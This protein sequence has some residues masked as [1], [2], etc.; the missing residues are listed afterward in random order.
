M[1]VEVRRETGR[2][3]FPHVGAP[4]TSEA[5]EKM[6]WHQTGDLLEVPHKLRCSVL[7][8]AVFDRSSVVV[9][10]H[11]YGR[12]MVLKLESLVQNDAK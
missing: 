3:S 12:F 10:G 11:G 9:A 2:A 7:A 5:G 6:A 1:L 8:V 4:V